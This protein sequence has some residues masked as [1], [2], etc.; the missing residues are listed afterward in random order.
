MRKGVDFRVSHIERSVTNTSEPRTKEH[1]VSEPRTKERSD[2]S[3]WSESRVTIISH[4]RFTLFG[5]LTLVGRFASS[6][7]R[8]SDSIASLLC[9]IPTMYSFYHE[10]FRRRSIAL[11]RNRFNVSVSISICSAISGYFIPSI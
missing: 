8:G 7:V 1:C 3:K 10:R 11:S 9:V 4:F 6:R 5:P 2:W